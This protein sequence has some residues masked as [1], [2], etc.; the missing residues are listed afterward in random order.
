MIF[1]API[2]LYLLPLAGLPVLFHFFL[3]QKKRQILF[4]TLMFFYRTDPRLNSRRKIHQILLLAMRVLLIAFVLLALSRPKFRSALPMGGKISVVAVVDNSGSMSDRA[5]QDKTKL[6]VAL[7]GASRLVSS[8]AESARMNVVTLVED[9]TLTFGNAL[10]SDKKSLLS[11]LDE[12]KPTNA[13]GSAARALAR[14][15]RLLEA[16][17]KAGGVIHVFS[18]LQES[19]WADEAL[20]SESAGASI[21]VYLHRI[22]SEPRREANVAISSVQL[23]KQKILPRHPVK[24]GVVC[25]NN[26][27]AVATIQVNSIDDRDNKSTEQVVLEPGR[28]KIV[29]VELRLD[30]PGYHWARTW[31]EGDGF[32]A[33]NEAGIG[34]M[35]R[36]T[37]SVLFG[38][39][40]DEFG[41]LPAALSPDESGQVTGMVSRFGRVNEISQAITDKP[42]LVIATWRDTGQLSQSSSALRQYVEGGGNLLIVP[43]PKPAGAAGEPAALAPGG[44]LG[45]GMKA[46]VFH[47]RGVKIEAMGKENDFWNRIRAAAGEASLQD[48]RVFAFYPLAL[49]EGFAPL[50][51]ADLDK[52]ILAHRELGQGNIYV[53]GTAFDPQWNTLPLTGFVVVMAQSIAVA[54]ASLDEDAVISLAA[55][56]QVQGIPSTGSG[57]A[58]PASQQLD[59]VSLAG[60]AG[61]WKQ[62]G[63]DAL[64]FPKPGV[65][66]VKAG[67]KE[68]CVCVRSSEK[69]G[70]TQFLGGS[71]VPTLEHVTHS[72][73]DYD[74]TE[75]LAKYHYGQVRTFELF[76]PLVLLATL[77]MLAEGWLANPI[78]AKSGSAEEI[79][80][81]KSKI[82]IPRRMQVERETG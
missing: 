55:G 29:E 53:S 79:E 52:V 68:Y 41:V 46:R 58:L 25:R 73:V 31:I 3:R 12:I 48:E 64:V 40:A 27:Q 47:P 75:D 38:G 33:D 80:N 5:G 10:T 35:C 57:Q 9:P 43:S 60:D 70:L 20:R 6:D 37:A 51:G 8:L 71:Q 14:A 15:I 66:L 42:I 30:V 16:D 11:L 1:S 24:A 61:E 4:P 59:I 45:A 44:W 19:E 34:I 18:D 74:P 78:R 50:L 22:E 63:G 28:T 21:R 26:S 69:E 49:S 82:E 39:A 7:E 2:F 65:Y 23:P 77:A 17:P 13:T 81:R 32:S 76:L 67:E 54:G 62:Q 72:V 36:P 56:E